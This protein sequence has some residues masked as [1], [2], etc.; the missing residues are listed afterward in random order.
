MD[1][2]DRATSGPFN[3]KGMEVRQPLGA[4][5]A[6]LGKDGRDFR[7]SASVSTAR[8]RVRAP[9]TSSSN[10]TRNPSMSSIGGTA[11]FTL[12]EPDVPAVPTVPSVALDYDGLRTQDKEDFTDATP[13]DFGSF[14]QPNRSHTFPQDGK[15]ESSPRRPSEPTKSNVVEGERVDTRR[16]SDPSIQ[17]HKSKAS[18]MLP[19]YEIGSTSSFRPSKSLRGRRT[20]SPAVDLSASSVKK[21]GGRDDVRLDDSPP[22]PAPSNA[23]LH[24]SSDLCH[25]PHESVSSNESYGSGMKS[26]S[27]RS[28]PPLNSPLQN[29][30]PQRP[31]GSS[32]NDG[33]DN[34]LPRLSIW[35]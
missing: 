10:Y 26:G 24:D 33:M 9:S 17:T 20:A 22:V 29:N 15:R 21:A 14:G 23:Q 19:L 6:A 13:F 30:S 32:R 8:S 18:V 35:R 25:T 16:P 2:S 31:K 7:R 11:R 27:S 34:S 28:S 1:S 3:A 4:E 12:D 5:D